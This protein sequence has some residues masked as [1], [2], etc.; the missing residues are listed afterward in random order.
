MSGAPHPRGDA[1]LLEFEI[2]NDVRHI[3]RVVEEI[4]AEC[5][6]WRYDDR[7]LALNVPVA[8]TEALS[9]AILRGNNDD[10]DKLVRVRAWID[11]LQLVVEIMDQGAG[12]DLEAC[13]ADPTTPDRLLDEDGR[14]LYLM[15]R[16]MDQVERLESAGFNVVRMTL[17][18]AS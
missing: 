2:P 13:A 12:F 15:L 17:R 11:T 5:R 1:R 18:R 14:G 7:Q 9:N 10:R 4:R 16:L 3:E 6:R 8:L